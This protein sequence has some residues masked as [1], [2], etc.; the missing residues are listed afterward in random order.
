[1]ISSFPIPVIMVSQS[2]AGLVTTDLQSLLI[3]S[4]FGL[5]LVMTVYKLLLYF[6]LRDRAYIYYV[7]V[8]LLNILTLIDIKV[9]RSFQTSE[10]SNS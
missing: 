4:L 10:I 6:S 3:G 7:G 2:A 8:T 5:M 1:M 9:L